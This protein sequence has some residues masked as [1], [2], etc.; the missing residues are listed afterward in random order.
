MYPPV[1]PEGGNTNTNPPPNISPVMTHTRRQE[2]SK[3]KSTIHPYS[4]KLKAENQ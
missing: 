3:K 4:A 2:Q 1:A